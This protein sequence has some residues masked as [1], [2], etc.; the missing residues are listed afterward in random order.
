MTCGYV[1]ILIN[2]GFPGMVKIGHT[3]RDPEER[4]RELHGTGVPFPFVIAYRGKLEEYYAEAEQEIHN[5]LKDSRAN[6]NREFFN[7][8]LEYAIPVVMEVVQSYQN[9]EEIEKREKEKQKQINSNLEK[10][11]KEPRKYEFRRTS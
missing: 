5:R 3:T 1:Y 9:R 11:S 10:K 2:P 6:N 4:A 8:S 7:L